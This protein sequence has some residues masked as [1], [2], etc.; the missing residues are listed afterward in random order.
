M[1][2][3]GIDG[4]SD[5]SMSNDNDIAKME[6]AFNSYDKISN[7][8]RTKAYTYMKNG[9]NKTAPTV[10]YEKEIGEKSYYVVQAVPETKKRTLYVV[11]AFIGKKGYKKEAS[12]LINAKSLDVT[13]KT[14]SVVTSN[15]IISNPNENVKQNTNLSLSSEKTAPKKYGD[16]NVYGDD[17][18]YQPNEDIAPVRDDVQK[19]LLSTNA[20]SFGITKPGDYV[21]V[22]RQVFDTLSSEGF[23]SDEE[24]RSRTVTNLDSSM[25]VEINKKGIKETFNYDNYGKFSRRYKGMKLAT[26]RM[27]PQ[28]IENGKLMSDN[29]DNYHNEEST[30]KFAYIESEVQI[31]GQD[32]SVK[33]DIKKSP[34]KNKF[35]V[36]S[37]DIKEEVDGLPVNESKSLKRD[38]IPI[39]STESI[40]NN[41]TNV[42]SDDIAPVRDDVVTT[43][44]KRDAITEQKVNAENKPTKRSELHT[45]IV[46]NIRNKYTEKGFDRRG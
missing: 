22:Q 28:I 36:H 5:Q 37:V 38:Y 25:Q 44:A 18:R 3:H 31:D 33:I 9:H 20:K 12:Q 23:F 10:L 4:K 1:K 15:N 8:G 43:Q 46:E 42:N 16:Y 30:V 26:V 35:W 32:V 39:N 40:S 34:Q 45:N 14:G 21:H 11:T 29:V 17:I 24:S 2:D 13:A 27:L 7:G 41:D 6:I 19:D